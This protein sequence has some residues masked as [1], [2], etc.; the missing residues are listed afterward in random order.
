MV[1]IPLARLQHH[2]PHPPPPVQL[3]PFSPTHPSPPS[4]HPP[5]AP[6]PSDEDSM[7]K[8]YWLSAL[9]VAAVLFASSSFAQPLGGAGLFH[10]LW[11]GFV[12]FPLVAEAKV[13][14]TY[15]LPKGAISNKRLRNFV[16]TKSTRY[17]VLALLFAGVLLP[18]FLLA[19]SALC[20]HG[21][22]VEGIKFWGD[23]CAD[24]SASLVLSCIQDV[25][26]WLV[27][28]ACEQGCCF[29]LGE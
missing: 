14:L 25:A 4:F 21:P 13:L 27:G 3:S 12:H 8:G 9:A 22:Q 29:V 11:L 6:H 23:Q 24:M 5:I 18:L 2:N 7:Q 16:K 17:I 28:T 1:R 15:V 26:G 20:L 19:V 10:A